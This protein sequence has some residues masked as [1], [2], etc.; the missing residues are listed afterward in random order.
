MAAVACSVP[1]QLGTSL[2]QTIDVATWRQ[3]E[4]EADELAGLVRRAFQAATGH[5]LATLRRDGSPRVSGTE[6]AFDGTD[7]TI[8]SMTGAV[9]ARD[10]QRD[11]RFAL[12]SSPAE[13]GDAKVS[14]V[15]VEVGS[16]AERGSHLFRLDLE[17][18][19]FTSL[20]DDGK[21]LLIQVWRPGQPVER[22][23][24]Y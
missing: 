3:F 1:P 14:G 5:V 6:V 11:G 17:Q 24:R 2:C 8:G 18:A 12:H 23:K 7:M 19:V 22:V 9:K 10:L 13:S 21:H 16:A 4:F 15:A 20:G